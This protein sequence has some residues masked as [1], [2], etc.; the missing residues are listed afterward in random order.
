[1]VKEKQQ[2]THIVER[3]KLSFFNEVKVNQYLNVKIEPLMF[4]VI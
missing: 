4:K 1:M 3:F 2:Y